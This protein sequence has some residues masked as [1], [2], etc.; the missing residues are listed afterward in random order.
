MRSVLVS[1]PSGAGVAQAEHGL[2]VTNDVEKGGGTYLPDADPFH[3]AQAWVSR[4]QCVVGGLLPPCS[5]K[6]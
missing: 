5:G 2:L 4:T 1:L 3:P 6:C